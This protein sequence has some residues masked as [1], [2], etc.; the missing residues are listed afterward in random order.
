MYIPTQKYILKN[1]KQD[2]YRFKNLISSWGSWSKISKLLQVSDFF[3]FDLKVRFLISPTLGW[4]F[5]AKKKGAKEPVYLQ[6]PFGVQRLSIYTTR[7]E[8]PSLRMDGWDGISKVS[9]NFL[10]TLCV[11]RSCIYPLI[12]VIKNCHVHSYGFQNLMPS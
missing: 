8:G 12:Y 4:P 2:P 9:L 11:Y 10:N 1:C 3:F 5:F 6:C 7:P